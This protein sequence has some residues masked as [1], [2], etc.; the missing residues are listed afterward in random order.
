MCTRPTFFASCLFFALCTTTKADAQFQVPLA[1]A[2][3]ADRV[4]A[5]KMKERDEWT[6]RCAKTA[7]DDTVALIR[8]ASGDYQHLY[9]VKGLRYLMRDDSV[10][11]AL[12]SDGKVQVLGG[13]T[14][15]VSETL[16]YVS[17]DLVSGIYGRVHFDLSLAEVVAA[18][19]TGTTV[20]TRKQL[21]DGVANVMR[22][23]NN[24]G[25][26]TARIVVPMIVGGGT[27]SQHSVGIVFSGGAIGPLGHKDSLVVN[28][29]A[30]LEAT[31]T[32][33]IRDPVSYSMNAELVL[34]VRLGINYLFR[35]DR[36]AST[37]T[38]QSLPFL[39]LAA[40][41]RQNSKIR[42][43]LLLTLVPHQYQVFMPKFQ[44]TIQTS[45]L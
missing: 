27:L 35:S 24:A 17:S 8:A 21:S 11:R 38:G 1:P 30:V 37:T 12:Y 44:I 39:Q 2:W 20:A 41:V 43:G 7:S 3:S 31:T 40:G 34:G 18:S 10:I 42:F 19:D 9:Y 36:I 25:T 23:V 4:C 28:A 16:A 5:V 29:G 22:L 6:D 13:F 33:S 45:A 32:A 14:T 15:A 26:V